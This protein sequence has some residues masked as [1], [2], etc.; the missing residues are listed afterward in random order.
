MTNQPLTNNIMKTTTNIIQPLR[1]HL[2]PLALVVCAVLG[3]AL[4]PAAQAGTITEGDPLIPTGL[5]VGDKFHFAFHTTAG[6]LPTSTAI[7]DYN[8]YVQT[9]AT[10]TASI[11]KNYGWSWYC[12]GSTATVHAKDNAVVSA[13]V[14]TL[15]RSDSVSNPLVSYLVA[16]AAKFW[17]STHLDG[18]RGRETGGTWSGSNVETGTYTTGLGKPGHE[19][20]SVSQDSGDAW[21]SNASWI[22]VGWGEGSNSLYALSELLTIVTSTPSDPY[23]TWA[24]TGVA[25]D[26]DANN[27][28]VDN[29]MAWVLGAGSTSVDAT[30]L[31][32]T[33]DN[34]NATYF[35]FTYNRKDDA[36]TDPNTIIK[37]E[38]CSDLTGWTT[39]VHD[40]SNIIITPTDNGAI[41]SVEVKI[42]R[43]LAV[44]DKLFARLNVVK[45]P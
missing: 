28:G 36:N 26:A 39:A 44:G 30:S 29:G 37:V 31:L 19:L 4:A 1:H 21:V 23:A 34:T 32:P 2:Q 35:I 15:H 38:Y 25:F 22:Q 43:T 8:A 13:P 40:N 5:V 17:T 45:T 41:D 11:F 16:T 33:L 27:D 10:S 12:I 7:A 6:T 24:G 18:I 14:Y 3:L 42:K 20:G 9:K